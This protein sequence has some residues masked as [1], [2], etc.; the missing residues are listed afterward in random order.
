[1]S[2]VRTTIRSIILAQMVRDHLNFSLDAL[3][4]IYGWSGRFLSS[5]FAGPNQL[6]KCYNQQMLARLQKCWADMF[7]TFL[8]ITW[9][10]RAV[11]IECQSHLLNTAQP[12]IIFINWKL[13]FTPN[14][15]NPTITTVCAISTQDGL[16]RQEPHLK[17]H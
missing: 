11:W 16:R 12:N 13:N 17:Q 9:R 15:P 14:R 4:H 7:I 10:L 2:S 3:K 8:P 1:M 6:K 5:L